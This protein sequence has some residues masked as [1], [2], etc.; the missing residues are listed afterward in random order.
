MV[1]RSLRVGINLRFSCS[2]LRR[3]R[4]FTAFSV[5]VV[6]WTAIPMHY[7]ITQTKKEKKNVR[8]RKTCCRV[9]PVR[10]FSACLTWFR[11]TG[12]CA[13]ATE[14]PF[15]RFAHKTEKF[16]N[17]DTFA[18]RGAARRENVMCV[19]MNFGYDETNRSLIWRNRCGCYKTILFR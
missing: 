17:Y 19:G 14:N 13:V 18:M 8:R 11:F 10:S 4:V 7:R 15:R 6:G 3:A 5:P 12:L 1:A 2:W 16:A 9:S